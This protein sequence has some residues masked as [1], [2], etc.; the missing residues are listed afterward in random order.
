[1]AMQSDMNDIEAIFSEQ[2]AENLF[3]YGRDD[4]DEKLENAIGMMDDG[5]IESVVF[6]IIGVVFAREYR[7]YRAELG[8]PTSL[9]DKQMA[10]AFNM[11][12]KIADINYYESGSMYATCLRNAFADMCYDFEYRMSA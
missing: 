9:D 7:S 3:Y 4:A 6:E 12:I 10:Q 2:D 11:A 8:E 1:M 5:R